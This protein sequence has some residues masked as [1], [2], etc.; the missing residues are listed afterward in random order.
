MASYFN[1]ALDTLCPG[2]VT[3]KINGGATYCT[4]AAVTLTIG[5]SD[6]STAG[7]QMLIWGTSTV[8]AETNAAWETYAPSKSVTLASGDGLKHVSVKIRD[9]VGNASS[10]VSDSITLDTTLPTVT[11]SG[12]DKSTI[13]KITGYNVAAFSFT[14]SEAFTSYKVKAVPATNS[15]HSAGTQIGVA[16]GSTNMSGSAGNYAANTAIQCTINGSD[17]STADSGDGVKVIKV[18]VLDVSG[19]WSIA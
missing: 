14:C 13:S 18:F 10:A 11:I 8:A 3:L 1:L 6:S 15:I 9:A 4:T 19:N 17:L 16:G 12:P 2:G 5:T 7:Y